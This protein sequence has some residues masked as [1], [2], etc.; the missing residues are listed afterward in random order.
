VNVWARE[1]ERR[2]RSAMLEALREYMVVD[3]FCWISLVYTE[4]YESK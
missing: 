3:V 4:E 2:E 1:V